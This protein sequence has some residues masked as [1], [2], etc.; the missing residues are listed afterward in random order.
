MFA[1]SSD[2]LNMALGIG[3]LVLVV[4]ISM[5]CFYLVLILRDVSKVTDEVQEIIYRIHK[6]IVEPLKAIDYLVE[7]ARPYIETV[8]EQKIKEKIKKKK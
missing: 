4:F 5:V 1:T 3:F 8:M 2:F 7:K 6:T